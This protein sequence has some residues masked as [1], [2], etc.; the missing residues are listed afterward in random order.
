M[1]CY[2]SQSQF[3]LV[4]VG[5]G[6]LADYYSCTVC[7]AALDVFTLEPFGIKTDQRPVNHSCSTLIKSAA[8]R[9]NDFS[10]VLYIL[11]SHFRGNCCA[12]D[13]TDIH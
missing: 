3:A 6:L 10:Y 2:L 4:D 12:R 1:M 9:M 13:G 11:Y 5:V 7:P 8:P